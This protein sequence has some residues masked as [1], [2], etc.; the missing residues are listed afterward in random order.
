M[1]INNEYLSLVDDILNNKN[2]KNLK[3]FKHHYGSTRFEHSF[4][5]SYYSY[6][7]CKFLKLD[8]ISAARGGLLHDLFFYDNSTYNKPN[9]HLWKHPKISLKNAQK[10]FDLNYKECDIILKHMW[11]IT[12]IPPKYLESYVITIID[13]YCALKEWINYCYNSFLILHTKRDYN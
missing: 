11:P 2:F 4:S 6:K 8:Y 10:H 7:I 13:K 3:Y 1:K 5:V 12:I 9:F